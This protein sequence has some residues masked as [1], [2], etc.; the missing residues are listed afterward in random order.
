MVE[1]LE[2][3]FHRGLQREMINSGGG[4]EQQEAEP[5]NAAPDNPRCIAVSG[6]DTRQDRQTGDAKKYAAAMNKAIDDF[7][8]AVVT[9]HAVTIS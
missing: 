7:L 6:S 8:F 9:I 1:Y 2:R 4:K 3:S 5:V